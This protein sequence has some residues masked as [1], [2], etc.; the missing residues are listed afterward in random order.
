M[1][2]RTF[3]Y[4]EYVRDALREQFQKSVILLV[5]LKK[6]TFK[7]KDEKDEY[8]KGYAQGYS[9]AIKDVLELTKTHL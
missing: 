7:I 5:E 1:I 6:T 9:D 4:Q 2:H 8:G 3:D